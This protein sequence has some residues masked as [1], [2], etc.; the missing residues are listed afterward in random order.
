VEAIVDSFVDFGGLDG[1]GPT[2]F[3]TGTLTTPDEG[4]G[5]RI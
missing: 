3:A 2:A 1:M 5:I 4:S